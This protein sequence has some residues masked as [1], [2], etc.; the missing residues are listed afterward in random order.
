MPF[1][2]ALLLFPDFIGIIE[3]APNPID[4]RTFREDLAF[5]FAWS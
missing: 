4:A 2:V 3:P 5:R 1:N